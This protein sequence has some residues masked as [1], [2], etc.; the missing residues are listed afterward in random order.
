MS[1]DDVEAAGYVKMDLLGLAALTAVSNVLRM[2]GRNPMD[3]LE[4]IPEN[5][6]ATFKTLQSG[7]VGTGIFQFEGYSTAIGARKMGIRSV[8]DA[9]RCLALFRPAAMKSGHTDEYLEHRANRANVEHLHPVF[10][11]ATKDTF[12]VFVFQD[13]VIDVLRG[14]GMDYADL[15]DML[16]AVKA[17]NLLIASAEQTFKRIRP[18]F[19]QLCLDAGMTESVARKAWDKVLDFSDYGFNYAHATAYGLLAYRIA[20]LKTHHPLDFMCGLLQMAAGGKKEPQYQAE[21]RRMKI[22]IR[23]VN[24]NKS[25][26]TWSHDGTDLFRG[27]LSVK[28]IGPVMAEKLLDAREDGPFTSLEDLTLRCGK[29]IANKLSDASA[30][31]DLE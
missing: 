16:K 21:A 10:E 5:D 1:M 6:K 24:V 28:G 12:G 30:L 26:L 15:N 17:S 9:I 31:G 27:F 25:G 19:H 13:Q 7:E 4:W 8:Q 14:L 22:R 20:Y 18:I 29:G 3:G 2:I 11:E 23:R